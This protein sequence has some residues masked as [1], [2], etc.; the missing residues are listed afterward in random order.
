MGAGNLMLF[1][2][3]CQAADPKTTIASAGKKH[4]AIEAPLGQR[5]NHGRPGRWG[6]LLLMALFVG[7]H[8]L[9]L[10]NHLTQHVVY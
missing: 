3:S 8:Q 9:V 2:A 4:G 5:S 10:A 6:K 7:H 1:P